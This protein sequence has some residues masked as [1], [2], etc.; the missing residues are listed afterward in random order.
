MVGNENIYI[1]TGGGKLIVVSI[2]SGKQKLIYKISKGS[3]SRPYVNNR[4]LYVVKSNEIIKL[5]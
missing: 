2:E 5:N 3:I 4:N 1:S